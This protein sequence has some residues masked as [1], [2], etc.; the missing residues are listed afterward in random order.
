MEIR[1]TLDHPEEKQATHTTEAKPSSLPKGVAGVYI[2]PQGGS[3]GPCATTTAEG[4]T[5]ETSGLFLVG[6]LLRTALLPPSTYYPPLRRSS[7]ISL[8]ESKPP[9][10]PIG[11]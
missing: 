2:H 10:I 8:L 9:S 5:W 1:L 6:S 4:E 3:L 11:I 7:S